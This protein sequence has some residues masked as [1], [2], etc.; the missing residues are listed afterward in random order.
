LHARVSPWVS[1]AENAPSD[2]FDF[3][4]V[5]EFSLIIMFVVLPVL[6]TKFAFM[7]ALGGTPARHS[8]DFGS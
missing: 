5:K 6:T 7:M 3:F 2:I 1:T 4:Q 8:A